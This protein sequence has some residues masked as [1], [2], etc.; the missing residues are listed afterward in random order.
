M[1]GFNP[2]GPLEEESCSEE[3]KEL[4]Q[5]LWADFH[6]VLSLAQSAELKQSAAELRGIDETRKHFRKILLTDP[7]VHHAME[8]AK[9]A[10]FD[11]VT[12]LQFTVAHLCGQ[13]DQ[14]KAVLREYVDNN[15]RPVVFNIPK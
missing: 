1:L 9:Y 8:A 13:V 3:S 15:P 2:I 5:K 14:M 10:N 6:F 7:V 12:A 11:P 4:L